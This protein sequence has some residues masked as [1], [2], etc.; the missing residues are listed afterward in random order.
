[1]LEKMTQHHLGNKKILSG[2]VVRENLQLTFSCTGVCYVD[3]LV[4]HV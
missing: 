2:T 3:I 1:M 4:D